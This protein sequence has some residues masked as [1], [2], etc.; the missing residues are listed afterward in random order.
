MNNSANPGMAANGMNSND[1]AS[2]KAK[3]DADMQAA[4]QRC[5]SM[6]GDAQSQCMQ[7]AQAAY[8][9]RMKSMNSQNP[10]QQ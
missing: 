10:Q 3:A 8:H 4:K 1:M 7:Q 2:M 6:S 5:D 9:T